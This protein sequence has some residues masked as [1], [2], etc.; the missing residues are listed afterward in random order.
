MNILFFQ[1]CISPHQMPFIQYLP[2]FKE[3]K[4][5]IIIVPE[6]DLAERKNMGWDS[7]YLLDVPNI[8]FLINPSKSEIQNLYNKYNGANTWCLYSGINSFPFVS[9]CFKES[10]KY[11][12]KRGIITEPPFIYNHPLWQHA[13]R[14]AI[15]DLRFTKYI[16]KIFIMGDDFLNYYRFWSKR[17]QV[18]PFLYC[19]TWNER[20]NLP[21]IK[22]NNNKLKILYVGSLSHRKNVQL[23]LSSACTLKQEEQSLLHIGIIGDG[24]ERQSLTTIATSNKNIDVTFYG[25][26][27]MN[28]IPSIMEQYDILCL[29]SRYDG[30]GAVVNEALTL[31]LYVICS[32]GCGSK[33]LITQSNYLC[34]NIF[35][36]E[37]INNLSKILRDCISQKEIIRSN[38]N[39][40]IKWA[41]NN[42]HG[43]VVAQYFINQLKL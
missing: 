17:W 5:I 29:P 4:D 32:T 24:E 10:L 16:D 22:N 40:R 1:N 37:D 9:K 6:K 27:P 7:S 13:V 36:S 42:I 38:I 2:Y 39:N 14:F 30:W 21:L 33:Y 43:K 8:K 3:I 35:R 19:T 31:G 41:K 18:I 12:I 26:K 11:N 25:T 34:G 23:L 28:I 20:K 15:K